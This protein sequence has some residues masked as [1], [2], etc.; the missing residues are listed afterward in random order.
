M[1]LSILHALHLEHVEI[2][3]ETLLQM[4]RIES[5][6]CIKKKLEKGLWV[7]KLPMVFSG[8]I[9]FPIFFHLLL[10]TFN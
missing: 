1:A 9:L 6:L 10:V 2:L 3:N 5:V 7:G 8:I 4:Q